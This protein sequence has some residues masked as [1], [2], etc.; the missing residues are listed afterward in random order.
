MGYTTLQ[1]PM[2]KQLC[3]I[4]L[5]K[6]NSES[7]FISCF[8]KENQACNVLR[9]AINQNDSGCFG[10][11]VFS[12]TFDYDF[13]KINFGKNGKGKLHRCFYE[14]RKRQLTNRGA[15]Q[16]T[17]RSEEIFYLLLKKNISDD[18]G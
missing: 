18:L 1:L 13:G 5:P 4:R 10:C 15:M 2:V 9:I 14:K 12:Q 16:K 3:R 11:N 8:A 7:F 6:L 17:K